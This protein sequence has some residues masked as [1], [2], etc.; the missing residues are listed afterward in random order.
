MSF[1]D[2]SLCSDCQQVDWKDLVERPLDPEFNRK[3]VYYETVSGPLGRL[4]RTMEK[5]HEQLK[6]SKCRCCRIL[7]IIKNDD[8]EEWERRNSNVHHLEVTTLEN[9]VLLYPPTCQGSLSLL[10]IGSWHTFD[11][12]TGRD[13]SYEQGKRYIAL[14]GS[15]EDPAPFKIPCFV[16]DFGWMQNAIPECCKRHASCLSIHSL[17]VPGLLVIDCLAGSST[18]SIVSAPKPCQYI[19]LSYV[20]GSAQDTGTEVAPVIKDAIKVTVKLGLRFLWVDKYCIPQDD[21]EKHR[22]IHSMDKIY[23]QAYVTI[24]AAAGN[25][26]ADG[27]PGISTISRV[28]QMETEI[29]SY[30]CRERYTEESVQQLVSPNTAAS[31]NNWRFLPR[32]FIT[33]TNYFGLRVLVAEYTR[34]DLSYPRDSL[35]AFLGVLA[36]YERQNA[37]LVS[38]VPSKLRSVSRSI[39]LPSHIWGLPLREG[40]PI[41]DWYHI[42]PPKQQRPD[43]PTWSWSGWEGGIELGDKPFVV[44]YGYCTTESEYA[45]ISVAFLDKLTDYCDQETKRLHVTGAVFELKFATQKQARSIIDGTQQL[46]STGELPNLD[47]RTSHHHCVFEV[48]PEI[49]TVIRSKLDIEPKAED[50]TFG[51]F[52]TVEAQESFYIRSIIV[53]RKGDQSFTGIGCITVADVWKRRFVNIKG[54]TI[55]EEILPFNIKDKLF[56]GQKCTRQRICLE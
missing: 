25:T 12:K 24:I 35:N 44:D 21:S 51:L 26:A 15:G 42:E 10:K 28:A 19:A 23:S 45:P 11:N 30:H 2:E 14:F 34:R 1:K 29:V 38:Q 36:E 13:R 20:W 48:S 5:S 6:Y 49:F 22:L 41:L 8:S 33:D 16:E 32:Y 47:I 7:S 43:F 54:A 50:Q 55:D 4:V 37:A 17:L 9:Q 31:M 39:S 56:F 3:R 27:L 53:L 52:V 46:Q 40:V 18:L